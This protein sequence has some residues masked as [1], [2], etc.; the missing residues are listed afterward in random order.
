MSHNTH[1]YRVPEKCL[2]K[3]LR[4][5]FETLEKCSLWVHK[6]YMNHWPSQS[7][8]YIKAHTFLLSCIIIIPSI[9]IFLQGVSIHWTGLLDWTTGLT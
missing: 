8:A 4:N 2:Y 3:P 7:R 5:L 9:H 6:L 1:T